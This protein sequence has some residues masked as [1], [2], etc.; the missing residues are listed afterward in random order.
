MSR[1]RRN[2]SAKFKSELVIEL[3]KGEKDLNTIATENNIQPNLL[4]NWKKEFLDKASVVFNDTREDNLKEKLALERKEKAEYAKKVGQLTMQVDWVKKNLKKHLDLTTRVN[5][6]QNL[7]KTKELP[8][9]TGAALLDINRTSVY[10][11]GTPI[12]QEELDCKSII[13]RLH[14]DNPAWRAR[15]LSAQLKKRGYQVGRRKTRRYMNEMG[16]DPIYPKMNLSKRMQQ[17]KVCPYLLRNA[18]I[19]RPNQ[20]WSIDITYIPIKHGFQYLT[21]VIDWYSR[22]TVGW[23][24]DTLDTRMVITALKKAFIVAKPVILNSD[25]GCQFTSNEYMNF[26][27]ENQIRQSMDGKSRWADNIMIERWFRSFKYEEA[28]LTQYN[29]IR[30][31]R[32][33]IGKYVHTYN[34]ERCHSALNNQTPASCYYPILLLDDHAA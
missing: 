11:K 17:A 27:K 6:V 22:C 8:V 30:E 28:Y 1:T 10:Y 19:D 16:I 26:L 20:A 33:A 25:Q 18:V 15:Q 21:A 5:L 13:D 2:F 3:L 34:F 7:L 12:S 4:R 23:V 32:K 29:N 24:D 9:K 31:A 14:T